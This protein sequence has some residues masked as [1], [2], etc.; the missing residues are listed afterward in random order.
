[1]IPKSHQVTVRWVGIP[2]ASHCSETTSMTS[3]TVTTA[4]GQN[5][6][7]DAADGLGVFFVRNLEFQNSTSSILIWNFNL[8][9]IPFSG[10][11]SQFPSLTIIRPPY[12]HGNLDSISVVWQ[13][14]WFVQLHTA[15]YRS[16]TA[17][18]APAQ[19]RAAPQRHWA[20][21]G[22]LL[23]HVFF[24]EIA[25]LLSQKKTY[26]YTYIISLYKSC[27]LI[28]LFHRKKNNK[29]SK[30]LSQ[31]QAS[32]VFLSGCS[33]WVS[34]DFFRGDPGR[35]GGVP[36]HPLEPIKMREKSYEIDW[37]TSKLTWK[38]WFL[39]FSLSVHLEHP[40]HWFLLMFFSLFLLNNVLSVCLSLHKIKKRK[41]L[42]LSREWGNDP[43]LA[44]HNPSNLQQPIHSLR[45]SRTSKKNHVL[46]V[47]HVSFAKPLCALE[48]PNVV[49]D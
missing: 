15:W 18:P 29:N 47:F 24:H 16:P 2:R 28:S 11:R 46:W 3:S 19:W 33:S 25:F 43:S 42:V 45:F 48:S 14:G 12:P 40:E 1:M 37:N 22:R 38:N 26:K 49:S 44:I 6:W 17:R 13:P 8:F 21:L 39:M 35:S 4:T 7:A 32:P 27:I 20:P 23:A 34:R 41:L 31:N 36:T 10:F 30:I 5:G 9:N